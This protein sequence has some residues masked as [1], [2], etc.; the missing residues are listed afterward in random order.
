MVCL[1]KQQQSKINYS[2]M[3]KAGVYPT[4]TQ[5]SQ[6]N[7]INANEGCASEVILSH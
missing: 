3:I 2:K 1:I 6:W 5:E 4:Y 7:D